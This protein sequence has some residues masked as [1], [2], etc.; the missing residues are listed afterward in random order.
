MIPIYCWDISWE[1]IH[2]QAYPTNSPNIFHLQICKKCIT[3]DSCHYRIW[4]KM[5]T[6]HLPSS[7]LNTIE[8]DGFHKII[9]VWWREV[10]HK[11][12]SQR[13]KR[14]SAL[15]IY[16]TRCILID[17]DD[18]LDHS[19]TEPALWRIWWENRT[20][21]FPPYLHLIIVSNEIFPLWWMATLTTCKCKC[22]YRQSS[23][24]ISKSK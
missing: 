12:V 20:Y 10:Q 19:S 1:Q 9:F 5:M 4:F 24:S 21:D 22:D 17:R 13:A 15:Q 18:T 3:S 6:F 23:P 14:T 8:S 7:A 16:I 11:D 2:P